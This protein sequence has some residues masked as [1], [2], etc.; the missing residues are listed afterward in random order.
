VLIK[1][2]LAYFKNMSDIIK[3]Y[4]LP[5]SVLAFHLIRII[6]VWLVG[7]LPTWFLSQDLKLTMSLAL[8]LFI[9][10]AIIFFVAYLEYYYFTLEI[11]VDSFTVRSGII[12]K[13][14]KTIAFRSIQSL[15]VRYDPFLQIFALAVVNIWSSS[16]EQ[17]NVNS[18]SSNNRPAFSFY[19]T[20][21]EAEALKQSIASR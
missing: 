11:G 12:V 1:F 14:I 19:M 9:L 18:G 16:P 7:I 17:L 4:K 3:S 6:I 15:D 21:F 8:I 10:G 20:R 13:N 5:K 2:K